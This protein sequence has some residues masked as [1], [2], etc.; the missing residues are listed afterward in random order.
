M[1][2]KFRSTFLALAVVLLPGFA[3]AENWVGFYTE[4]WNR[5]SG[6]SGT[7]LDFSNSY[8]YDA[9]SIVRSASGDITLWI[10]EVSEN[11]SYYVK[12][13]APRKETLFRKVHL[14]CSSQRYEVIQD[15]TDGDGAN[16]LLSEE[17]KAGSYYEKLHGTVCRLNGR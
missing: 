6:R 17:I 10:K 14:W 12:K 11:D 8:F 5:T 13:G 7:K 16:K 3:A 4:K 1:S 9:D 2:A 15:D